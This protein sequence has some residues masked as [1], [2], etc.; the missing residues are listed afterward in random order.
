MIHGNL[1]LVG[2]VDFCDEQ[3][4]KIPHKY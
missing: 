3:G 2:S 1:N 4:G